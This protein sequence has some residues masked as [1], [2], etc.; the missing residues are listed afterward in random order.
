MLLGGEGC[1]TY[2]MAV[3]C[4]FHCLSM[5]QMVG[6]LEEEAGMY[7]NGNEVGLLVIM[8]GSRER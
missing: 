7:M 6:S 8:R 3:F 4:C 5:G 2:Y 1:V